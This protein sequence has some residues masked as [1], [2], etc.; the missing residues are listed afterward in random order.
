MRRL[1]TKTFGIRILWMMGRIRILVIGIFR[2]KFIF[3]FIFIR[4]VLFLVYEITFIVFV[5]Y[6]LL[7]FLDREHGRCWLV[8]VVLLRII[9]IIATAARKRSSRLT[10]YS[11]TTAITGRIFHWRRGMVQRIYHHVVVVGKAACLSQSSSCC[12]IM[13]YMRSCRKIGIRT[14]GKNSRTRRSTS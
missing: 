2:F 11:A 1:Q 13:L 6:V 3:I 8:V 12:D 7:I 5:D 9:P 14:E 4:F 10:A